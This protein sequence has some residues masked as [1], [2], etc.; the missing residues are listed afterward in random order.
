MNNRLITQELKKALADYP[1]YSQ[2]GKKKDALCIAVFRLGKVRW[3]IT[4]GQ[5]EGS[6]FTFYGITVGLFEPEYGY[7]SANE[8]AGIKKFIYNGL[9]GLGRLMIEQN[10]SFKPC[11]L[12]DIK[13]EE[14]QGFLSSLYD[15]DKK[16]I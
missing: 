16:E 13:D 3:Y 6:D 5:P 11:P 4:E 7:L 2:D 8:M 9:Y 12:A 14:L 10:K 1:L 15:R